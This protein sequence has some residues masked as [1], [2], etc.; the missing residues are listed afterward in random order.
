MQSKFD[1]NLRKRFL[2][3][4]MFQLILIWIEIIMIKSKQMKLFFVEH[5]KWLVMTLSSTKFITSS[6]KINFSSLWFTY[7]T[8]YNF[9]SSFFF[10]NNRTWAHEVSGLATLYRSR[11]TQIYLF[12]P[13][14][15]SNTLW[16][17]FSCS[18]MSL[19][20]VGISTGVKFSYLSVFSAALT[21]CFLNRR[22][23]L[24]SASPI[25][26]F[27]TGR[28]SLLSSFLNTVKCKSR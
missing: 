1:F 3:S 8:C 27:W 10:A 9:S 26:R 6:K 13:S 20:I 15:T 19:D 24:K 2:L 18:S 22:N 17:S 4:P 16:A 12:A 23:W 11:V 7:T 28:N 25:V 14:T 21:S 5:Y